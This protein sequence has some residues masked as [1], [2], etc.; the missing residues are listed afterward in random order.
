MKPIGLYIHWP[1][2]LSKCPYCDF[3][4]HVRENVDQNRWQN[5][6]LQELEEAALHLGSRKL[7]SIFFGGG[8]PSLMNPNT[9]NALI[10]K[11]R[12]LFQTS[13]EIEITLEANPSTVEAE[14]F[15]AFAQAGVNR[16]SIGVQSLDDQAL[17]FLGRRHSAKEALAALEIATTYFPRFSFDLIYARP[18]QTKRAWE[19]ELKE[20]LTYAQGHM[21]LYQ[22]T[23]EPQTLFATRHERGEK[24]TLEDE[25]AAQLYEL[26]EIMMEDAGLQPYE[27]SNY[28]S[29]L[30]ECQHNLLYWRLEDYIG[31]GPGAHG[32]LTKENVKYT[33]YRY[34]APETW[35]EA[36]EQNGQ[37]LQSTEILSSQERFEECVLMGLRLTEGLSEN[38]LKE[39]TGYDFSQVFKLES[40]GH[41][42]KEGLIHQTGTHLIP[43]FEGRLRLNSLIKYLLSNQMLVKSF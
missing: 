6:L 33:T 9:I 24:M 43:T 2:C 36:V 13:E 19:S 7:V 37:G 10:Q 29:P 35:L 1:F 34:K 3:N 23:I 39:E 26:T 41:L 31:I 32:R 27:V 42:N 11:A 17:A 21:S 18:D 16:L 28:A 25:P 8:T 30:Q 4:S 15:K 12:E 5:A 22:L 38:R 20:A 40:L 14:K